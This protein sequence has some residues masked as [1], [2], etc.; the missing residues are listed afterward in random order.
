MLQETVAVPDPE[1]LFGVIALQVRFA[2]T[3][4]VRLTVPAKP[5]NAATVIVELAEVPT[6]TAPGEVAAIVKS[7]T[8][9]VAVALCL[10]VPLVPVTVTT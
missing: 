9:T 5:F 6:V 10:R 4:S 1:R 8:T 7:E 3:A 2:G